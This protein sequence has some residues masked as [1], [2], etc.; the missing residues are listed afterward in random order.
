MSLN[1]FEKI[2]RNAYVLNQPD[3]REQYIQ[4]PFEQRDIHESLPKKV[5]DLFDDGY[6]SEATFEA[7]KYLDKLIQHLSSLKISGFKLMMDAF[8]SD[9]PKIMLTKNTTKTEKDEQ[10]GVKFI[11]AGAMLAIRNPRGHEY[12]IKDSPDQCLDHLSLASLLLRKIKQS[13]FSTDIKT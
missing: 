10:D 11:F 7:Y 8:S 2:V 9:Q 3:G 13:G 6:Y 5:K 4:H 1:Y 12:S